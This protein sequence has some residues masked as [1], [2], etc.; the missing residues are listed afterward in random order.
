AS[1]GTYGPLTDTPGFSSQVTATGA[2]WTAAGGPS[3]GSATGAGP[4]ALAPAGTTIAGNA[5]HT[6]TVAV[7]FTYAT[8]S[9]SGGSGGASTLNPMAVN[10]GFTVFTSGN[11]TFGNSEIEGSIASGG[12]VTFSNPSFAMIHSSGL[13]PTSYTLPVIDGDPTRL[14]VGGRFL[15]GS[16]GEMDVSSRGYVSADQLGFTKIGDLGNVQV[17]SRGP[18]M[19]W[20]ANGP[21]G[22]VQAIY[23]ENQPYVAGTNPAVSSRVQ[24]QQGFASYFAAQAA[25]QAATT[26]CL[27]GLS[28]AGSSGVNVTSLTQDGW[29]QAQDINIVA[30]K[31]NV[32]V[33]PA[34]SVIFSSAPNLILTGAPLNATTTLVI[35]VTG[36]ANGQTLAM[37]A[38]QAAA[39]T[40]ATQ[41]SI[42][43]P[44]TLWDFSGDPAGSSLTLTGSKVSGSI[45]A[46]GLSLSTNVSTPIEGSIFTQNLTTAGGEIHH[47]PFSGTLACGGSAV[48]TPPPSGACTGTAGSGLFNQVALPAG[49]ENGSTGNNTGCGVLTALQLRKQS[50]AGIAL[51]GSQWKLSADSGGSPGAA[52]IP[53]V[54][55]ASSTGLFDVTGLPAGTYWLTETQAPAGYALATRSFQFVIASDGTLTPGTAPTS[56]LTA[57]MIT[58]PTTGSWRITATDVVA[59]Q[60][61]LLGADAVAW[62][63]ISGIGLVGA[64]AVI[65]TAIALRRRTGPQRPRGRHAA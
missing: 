16:S 38:F 7:G 9:G 21:S 62:V 25:T 61:P 17:S 5:T 58:Q 19:V 13:A 46:P 50:P 32:L 48:V 63:G 6:Y 15:P 51:D 30:G 33:V 18:N 53:T 28:T 24:L 47:Y 39:N 57:A 22:T 27:T 29:A 59:Y 36:L 65:G 64:A 3:G 41:P 35:Q 45:Y 10:N 40:S 37:P 20:I 54:A 52:G 55:A 1:A 31:T 56:G 11:G 42:V 34:S 23:D 8:G 26:T 14:M 49:Q 4:Y 12:N 44:Y 2:T 43:A 60:L